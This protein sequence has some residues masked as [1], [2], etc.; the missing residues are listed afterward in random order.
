MK[1]KPSIT[2]VIAVKTA[3][4]IACL[5]FILIPSL[6]AQSANIFQSLSDSPQTT[7]SGDL[8]KSNP[9]IALIK[10]K[11]SRYAVG[12]I[13]LYTTARMAD[14]S[15]K[16]RAVDIFG[17]YQDPDFKPVINNTPTLAKKG[18]IHIAPKS[19]TEI[20][21][22]IKVSTIIVKEKSFLVGDRVFKEA[23]E[24]PLSYHDGKTKHLKVMKVEAKQIVFKDL[25]SK[26]EATLK[27][28]VLPFGMEA[29]DDRLKPAGMVIPTKNQ[30]LVLEIK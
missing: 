12:N 10:S 16:N 6:S 17:V 15:M 18:P 9:D 8:T 14:F 24:F 30:P 5:S 23:E 4:I 25:D 2:T 28:E 20:I 29:G 21:K 13:E 22:E 3:R 19:L 26:E 11:P 7:T 27:I 1:T